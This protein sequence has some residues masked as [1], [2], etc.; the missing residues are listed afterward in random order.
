MAQLRGKFNAGYGSKWRVVR[1]P[2]LTTE[3]CVSE[4]LL[5]GTVA[6]LLEDIKQLLIFLQ[7][8]KRNKE[9]SIQLFRSLLSRYHPQIGLNYRDVI[10][11]FIHDACKNQHQVQMPLDEI[12]SW[13]PNK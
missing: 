9:E 11:L 2:A 4:T 10:S 5:I 13:W 12:K 3:E 1:Q 7:R 6:Y 8:S